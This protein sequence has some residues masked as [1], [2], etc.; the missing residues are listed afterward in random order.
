[1]RVQLFVVTAAIAFVSAGPAP[2]QMS[3]IASFPPRTQI[4]K[5]TGASSFVR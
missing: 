3:S 2:P 4:E 5:V 1:M